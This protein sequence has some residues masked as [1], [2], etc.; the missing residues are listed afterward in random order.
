MLSPEPQAGPSG[1][2]FWHQSQ[3]ILAWLWCQTGRPLKATS[4]MRTLSRTRGCF[5][6]SQALTSSSSS[7][8]NWSKSPENEPVSSD[9]LEKN[10]DQMSTRKGFRR[11]GSGK[12]RILRKCRLLWP[13][14]GTAPV[15]APCKTWRTTKSTARNK[16]G[17]MCWTHVCRKKTRRHQKNING[18]LVRDG[19]WFQKFCKQDEQVMG[20]FQR[21]PL[22]RLYHLHKITSQFCQSGLNFV[23]PPESAS[24]CSVRATPP[25]VSPCDPAGISAV[26]NHSLS[27]TKHVSCCLIVFWHVCVFDGWLS[28]FN[29][30]QCMFWGRHWQTKAHYNPQ[31]TNCQQS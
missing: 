11:D 23:L 24:S 7:W 14:S 3:E 19:H 26:V 30:N 21:Y 25:I 28:R 18:T 20:P 29:F 8:T 31:T 13:R 1:L 5:G 27:K 22:W 12:R 16:R 17:E 6:P 2:P 15:R 9:F 4:V 10:P